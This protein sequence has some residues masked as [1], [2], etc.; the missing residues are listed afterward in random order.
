MSE[1]RFVWDPEKDR[2]NQKKH[3]VSFE[4]AK[5]VF[6]DENAK[7]MPDPDHSDDEDRYILLGFSNRLKLLI[8]CHCYREREDVIRVISAR[9]ATRQERGHYGR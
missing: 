5:S 8:V 9:S 4:E 7:F 6:Y 1:I 2:A 3:G